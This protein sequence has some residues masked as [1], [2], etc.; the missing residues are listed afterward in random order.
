MRILVVSD[1]L[2]PPASLG[3]RNDVNWISTAPDGPIGP[4]DLYIWDYTPGLDLQH[5]VSTR[6]NAQHLVVTEPKYLDGFGS[7]QN[8]VCILL[9]PVSPFTLKTCVELA[10]RSW[11]ARRQASELEALRLDRDV[12]LQYVLEVNLRLQEYDHERS[13]FLARA[14]HDFRAPLTALL[15]YCGLLAEGKLGTVNQ[16]QQDLLNRMRNST[17]RLARLVGG[18]LE[19][20]IQGRFEKV[21]KLCAAD[22]EEIFKE[23]LHDIYP[24]LEDKHLDV[25]VQMQAPEGLLLFE[26]EQ[27][28]QVFV[29]LLENS[30]KFTPRNGEVLVHGYP[31]CHVEWQRHGQYSVDSPGLGPMN[32]YRVDI[33]DSGPG[34]GVG[35]SEHIFE[36][37]TSYPDLTDRSGA[38]LGLAICKAIITA[39]AGKIWA[40]PSQEGGQFSFI[41]PLHASDRP[42]LERHSQ[43]IGVDLER[44][45]C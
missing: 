12:L 42:S 13:N 31:F 20:L 40:T 16:S 6:G 14:L 1:C 23:A 32:A 24:F 44:V 21:P 36:A 33:C 4:A 7:I 26:P 43:E 38:G 17:R 19:L 35:V 18:T 3:Q 5:C 39:H 10:L 30:C 15:G 22:I 9:K 29:N 11:E 28:Q 45:E 8:S 37:Y 2:E 27:L 34:V 41:L 25:N